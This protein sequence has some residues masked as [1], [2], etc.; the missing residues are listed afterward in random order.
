[1][2][3]AITIGRLEFETNGE[4]ECLDRDSDFTM[5]DESAFID[6]LTYWQTGCSFDFVFL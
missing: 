1:M 3:T 4:E 6:S 5:R 2:D